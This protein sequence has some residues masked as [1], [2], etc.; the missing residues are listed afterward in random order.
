M[1]DATDSFASYF[2]LRKPCSN[3]PFRKE[4]AIELRPGRLEGILDDLLANDR[5]TFP[6]HK[7]LQNDDHLDL[8][9]DVED[10]TDS[11]RQRPY[12]QGEKM[13]A[14]AATYLMKLQ[15]P[16]VGMRYAIL[17]GSISKDHWADAERMVIDPAKSSN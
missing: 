11:E 17:T 16:S 3:C 10:G 5:K 13:C 9:E 12:L 15:R 2:K 14:G 1:H 6:C 8:D 4:G 7:T